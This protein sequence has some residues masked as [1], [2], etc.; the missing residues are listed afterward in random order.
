ME[1]ETLSATFELEKSSR[2]YRV[3]KKR[4]VQLVVLWNGLFDQG[5]KEHLKSFFHR[6]GLSSRNFLK[7]KCLKPRSEY[8]EVKEGFSI[9]SNLSGKRASIGS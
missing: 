3:W 8:E 1:E 6:H 9:H 4:F 7:T 2:L 5:T